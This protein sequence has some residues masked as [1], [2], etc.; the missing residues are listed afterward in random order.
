M[1]SDLK[2]LDDLRIDISAGLDGTKRLFN[3]KSPV[4]ILCYEFASRWDRITHFM[5]GFDVMKC[6]Q[7]AY[8]KISSYYNEC[9]G[10]FVLALKHERH[11]NHLMLKVSVGLYQLVNDFLESIE[12]AGVNGRI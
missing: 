11:A 3:E 10:D 1:K 7:Y 12:E 6:N 5:D 4:A 8:F 2:I 9:R